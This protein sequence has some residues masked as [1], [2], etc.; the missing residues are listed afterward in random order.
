MTVKT[1]W[2]VLAA[3]AAAMLMFPPATDASGASCRPRTLTQAERQA[4]ERVAP[5]L[6]P[7]LSREHRPARKSTA[8]TRPTSSAARATA[9]PAAV[10][11]SPGAP[12][13]RL[14]RENVAH[15]NG[16]ARQAQGRHGIGGD[17]IT[18]PGLARR[19][20]E[21][22]SSHVLRERKE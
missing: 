9:R 3:P 7:L 11:A 18:Q 2:I 16:A 15:I 22:G 17:F 14:L 19:Q 13:S 1:S 8:R 6:R 20:S 10:R 21:S 5:R 4:G 12:P